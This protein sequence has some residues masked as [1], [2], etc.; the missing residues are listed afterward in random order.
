M[1]RRFDH[2][3]SLT[4]RANECSHAQHID[5]GQKD[6]WGTSNNEVVGSMRLQAVLPGVEVV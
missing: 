4:M 2:S 1:P 6:S 5:F 3:P